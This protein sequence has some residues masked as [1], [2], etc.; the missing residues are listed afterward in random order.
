M[1]NYDVLIEA[2]LIVW[3]VLI[4]LE[5]WGIREKA[6]LHA[7]NKLIQD[8]VECDFCLSHHL[9]GIVIYPLSILTQQI[10]LLLIPLFVGAII[11]KI[12]SY[13]E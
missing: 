3:V 2:T 12:R 5:K 11:T 8:A 4:L 1:I 6:F 13:D 9:T 7:P 10:D